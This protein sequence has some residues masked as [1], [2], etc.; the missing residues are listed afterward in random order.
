MLLFLLS[1][2]LWEPLVQII[3]TCSMLVSGNGVCFIT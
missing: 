2:E 1:G 3:C